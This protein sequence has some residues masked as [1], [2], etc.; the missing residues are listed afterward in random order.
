MAEHNLL[1]GSQLHEPKGAESAPAGTVYVADGL[2]SGAWS[3]EDAGNEV[4]INSIADFPAAVGGVITLEEG[5]RYTLAASVS[6]SNRFVAAAN[7]SITAFNINSPAFEYTGSGTF[8]T[9]VDVNFDIHHIQLNCPNGQLFDFSDTVGGTKIFTA[10]TIRL[11]QCGTFGTFDN[12]QSLVIDNSSCLDCTQGITLAGSSW[13][14]LSIL[15]FALL[16]SHPGFVGLNLGT[17]VHTNVELG[18]LLFI[19]TSGGT[20]ISG[21]ASSANVNANNIASVTDGTFS[22]ATPLSGITVDDVRYNFV[23][24]SNLSDTMSDALISTHS[25]VTE[26]TISTTSTPVKVSATFSEERASH[27]TTDATGR[28]TYIGERDIIVPVDAVFTVRS[29]GANNQEFGTYIAKNGVYETNSRAT[30]RC[31]AADPKV[32]TNIWQLALSE[33]DY[34]EVFLENNTSTSNLIADDCILQVN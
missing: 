4:I 6:T 23:G 30:N 12:M 27:F 9:G 25:N 28:I 11:A 16:T 32:T 10:D 7:N 18:N 2:G 17:S 34:I 31:D 24:N 14:V 3:S 19:A 15:K 26:T 1:T 5:K 29:A 22:V 21:A 20:G 8:F 33:N 13:V